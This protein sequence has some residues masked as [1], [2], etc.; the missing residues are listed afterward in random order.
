M[1]VG[2][3]CYLLSSA[4]IFSDLSFCNCQG[5]TAENCSEEASRFGK[6]N[7]KLINKLIGSTQ[8]RSQDLEK[9]EAFLNEWEVCKRPWPEFSL[10]LNQFHTV[11][12]KIETK[13]LGKLGNSKVFFAQNQVVSKKK[14]GFH[15]FWDWIFDP[16]RK[17]KRLRGLFS[18]GGGGY[19]QFFTI[20]IDLKTTKKV[21][22]CILHK[23]IGG[24]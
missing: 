11:C 19:F 12:T 22:F 16:T 7:V 1:F 14:K 15:R 6:R 20:K 10:L 23:P 24:L 3:Y 2:F 13:F 5:S 4:V 21:R 17:S 8:A 18:Y 9:G